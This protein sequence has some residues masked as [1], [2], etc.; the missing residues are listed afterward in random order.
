MQVFSTVAGTF[1][2]LGPYV[3]LE[4]LLPG[5]TLFALALFVYRRPATLRRYV[6]KAR[7]AAARLLA[8]VRK[9]TVSCNC[10]VSGS[11]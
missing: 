10:P 5:G 8:R 7:V 9:T 4:V 3:L 11:A 6:R 2:K 1:R